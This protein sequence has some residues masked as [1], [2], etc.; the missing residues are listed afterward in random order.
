ML[1]LGEN[2][3]FGLLDRDDDPDFSVK[4]VAGNKGDFLLVRAPPRSLAARHL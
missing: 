2:L 4:T 1:R 3:N